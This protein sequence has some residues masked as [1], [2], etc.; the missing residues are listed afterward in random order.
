MEWVSKIQQAYDA[1]SKGIPQ[2]NTGRW[3]NV[4]EADQKKPTPTFSNPTIMKF[5]WNMENMTPKNMWD[6]IC[7]FS[8]IVRL[9]DA[10]RNELKNHVMQLILSHNP[11]YAGIHLTSAELIN[12]TQTTTCPY[13]T[14]VALVTKRA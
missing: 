9:D 13:T 11:D 8:W 14:E 7:S 5:H 3:K 2:H 10:T 1:H 12:S 4:F 6:F